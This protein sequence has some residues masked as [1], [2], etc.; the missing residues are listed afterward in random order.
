MELK[1]SGVFLSRFSDPNIAEKPAAIL[2]PPH[3]R[4]QDD[5]WWIA[6]LDEARPMKGETE[7][8]DKFGRIFPA[9]VTLWPIKDNDGNVTAVAE[10]TLDFSKQSLLMTA[11]QKE[12]DLLEAILET[13]NDAILMI[14]TV[15]TVV[16][17][18]LE[19]ETFFHVPRY[20][21]INRSVDELVEQ[22][23][24]SDHV[25]IGLMNLLMTYAPDIYQTVAGDFENATKEKRVL[26]WYSA[27]VYGNDGT[28]FGRLFVF[29]D[30]T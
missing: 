22:L 5:A 25:P 15:R 2:I 9:Y 27:P 4:K 6:V 8:I 20:Q 28:V 14:D 29:R 3:R 18:N 30:A 16:T 24:N 21:F 7:R 13:S 19:F 1:S 17:A 12:R 10:M 26:V 11:L 23:R